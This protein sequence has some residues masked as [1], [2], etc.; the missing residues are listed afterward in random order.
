MSRP[1]SGAAGAPAQSMTG[2]A[3]SEGESGGMRWR[4]ELKS[5]NGRGLEL[6]LRL[7]SGWDALEPNLRADAQAQFTRGSVTAALTLASTS[8]AG[9]EGEEFARL[10][11]R[12]SAARKALIAA[13]LEPAP[14]SAEALLALEAAGRQPEAAPPTPALAQIL[15]IGF[16]DALRG[17]AAARK[18][19][20]ERIKATLAGHAAAIGRLAE[21]AD[22]EAFRAT[23]AAAELLKSRVAALMEAGAEVEPGRLAQE[24][25]LLAVKSDAREEIDR[26]RAHVAA[27]EALLTEGGAF[28]RKLDFLAQE[29]NREA[30]TLCA[31]SASLELTRIGL[32]LKLAID[33]LREQAQNLE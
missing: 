15:R 6:R 8:G 25:A 21:E 23:A 28:G 11:R 18:S 2:F 29:L 31:K 20:G 16:D 7:P 12:I 14:V 9:A 1:P 5:V 22:A 17:L 24:L 26:L 32:A 10:A 33:Q 3:A 27:V 30:N 13:G 4:W 19:E